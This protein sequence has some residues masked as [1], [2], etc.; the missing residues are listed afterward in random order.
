[1]YGV[2]PVRKYWKYMRASCSC[3]VHHL[4]P[5]NFDALF[6][7]LIK[8][9]YLQKM[10]HLIKKNKRK[11]NEDEKWQKYR[12]ETILRKISKQY[13]IRLSLREWRKISAGSSPQSILIQENGTICRKYE[14][15]RTL[16]NGKVV[17]G[18]AGRDSK[19][20]DG[21]AQMFYNGNHLD[22][23]FFCKY[24]LEE[25]GQQ[26][27]KPYE[28]S[29]TVDN[30]KNNNDTDCLFFFLLEG[31][32][33][34]NNPHFKDDIGFSGKSIDLSSNEDDDEIESIMTKAITNY[35]NI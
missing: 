35:F 25:G 9:V 21:F 33:W 19:A 18:V 24:T 6:V 22:L 5:Q 12:I 2:M 27:E 31:G 11:S 34:R 7:F 20:F 17:H 13:S 14:I 28:V 16:S 32:L 10:E 1:M 23:Y 15:E 8:I 3:G 30:I 4:R 26:C 29:K